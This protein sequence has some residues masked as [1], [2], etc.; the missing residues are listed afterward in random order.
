MQILSQIAGKK[1]VTLSFSKEYNLYI[2]ENTVRC[3][4]LTPSETEA[5]EAFEKELE[6][7]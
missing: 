4:K 7:A 6:A 2:V 3:V 1:T 5:L